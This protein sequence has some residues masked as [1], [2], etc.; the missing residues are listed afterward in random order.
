[1]LDAA[2]LAERKACHVAG[3]SLAYSQAAMFIV[4][5]IVVYFGGAEVSSGRATFENMLK[6]FMSIVFAAMGV[7]Q[8]MVS[9]PEIGKAGPAVQRMMLLLHPND[10]STVCAG[11][12]SEADSNI[13]PELV[14]VTADSDDV[15]THSELMHGRVADLQGH[16]A[17]VGVWFS[18]PTR[19]DVQV[20]QDFSLDIPARKSDAEWES[21][22]LLHSA[23]RACSVADCTLPQHFA[24]RTT[25]RCAMLNICLPVHPVQAPRSRWWAVPAAASRPSSPSCSAF[26]SLTAGLCCWM[27]W[28]SAAWTSAGSDNRSGPGLVDRR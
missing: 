16:V 28:T 9:F 7:A 24:V 14:L 11:D 10:G 6:A 1:M 20:L 21:L 27:A 3:L 22:Q 12:F 26:M 8:A 15:S 5:A 19:P 17:L 4:T 23:W 2:V 13:A 25:K 18:Y